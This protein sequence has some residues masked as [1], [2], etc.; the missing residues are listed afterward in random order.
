MS[1]ECSMTKGCGGYMAAFAIGAAVGAAVA[2]LYAPYSGR[3]SREYLAHRARDLKDKAGETLHDAREII[4]DKK[5]EIL[6]AFE[7]GREAMREEKAKLAAAAETG[8]GAVAGKK[9]DA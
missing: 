8:K 1:E 2:I 6:A 3:E 4:K 7:A 9:A 5:A